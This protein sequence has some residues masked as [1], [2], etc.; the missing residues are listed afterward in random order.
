M[1]VVFRTFEL[2]KY[3]NKILHY[4]DKDLRDL[5]KH[6]KTLY[7]LKIN[8]RDQIIL[9]KNIDSQDYISYYDDIIDKQTGII[10]SKKRKY[11]LFGNF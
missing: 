1:S 2:N 7:N 8:L 11:E 6:A 3:C 10:N 5:F 4:E 9:M